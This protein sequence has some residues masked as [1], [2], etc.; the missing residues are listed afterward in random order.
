MSRHEKRS[1]GIIGFAGIEKNL[2]GHT[3]TVLAEDEDG[4]VCLCKAAAANLPTNASAGFAVG[5]EFIATDSGAHY[6][7]TGT[8]SSCTFVLASSI[9]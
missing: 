2:G 6:Y 9:T 7:N 3:I 1:F 5:C 4:L 8:S